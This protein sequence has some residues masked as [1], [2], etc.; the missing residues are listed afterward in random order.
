M[1]N[2]DILVPDEFVP[3]LSLTKEEQEKEWKKYTAEIAE[4]MAELKSDE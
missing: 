1:K 2:K 3:N 4:A